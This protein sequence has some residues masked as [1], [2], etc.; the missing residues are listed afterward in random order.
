MNEEEK[1][2]PIQMGVEEGGRVSEDLERFGTSEPHPGIKPEN[3]RRE[4]E[5]RERESKSSAGM[6]NQQGR[7]ARTR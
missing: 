4:G 5:P 7:K 3:I 1:R 6:G 2:K